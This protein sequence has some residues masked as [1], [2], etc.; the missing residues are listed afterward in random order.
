MNAK[1]RKLKKDE[2]ERKARLK[3]VTE[4]GKKG[5]HDKVQADWRATTVAEDI[6]EDTEKILDK[7]RRSYHDRADISSIV[8]KI[9]KSRKAQAD[10]PRRG[11]KSKESWNL[12]EVDGEFKRVPDKDHDTYEHKS[13]GTKYYVKRKKEK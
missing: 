5:G 2:E 9:K 6:A 4:A 1:Q 10:S 11:K 12:K 7:K 3:R 8:K 13:W